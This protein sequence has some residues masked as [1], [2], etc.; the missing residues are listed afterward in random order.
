MEDKF[1][2]DVDTRMLQV[3]AWNTTPRWVRFR[4]GKKRLIKRGE[5]LLVM[6]VD[7]TMQPIELISVQ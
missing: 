4:D 5:Y 3:V 1:S 2:Y 6:K 7:D